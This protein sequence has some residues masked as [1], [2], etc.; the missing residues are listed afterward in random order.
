[1]YKI[2]HHLRNQ[3]TTGQKW[4]QV[5]NRLWNYLFQQSHPL[6]VLGSRKWWNPWSEKLWWQFLGFG[7]RQSCVQTGWIHTTICCLLSWCCHPWS[8]SCQHWCTIVTKV[9]TLGC[10]LFEYRYTFWLFFDIIDLLLGC[11]DKVGNKGR[12]DNIWQSPLF[13]DR[14]EP[15]GTEVLDVTGIKC[16]RLRPILVAT[17]CQENP[18]EYIFFNR[19]E[20]S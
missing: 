6:W 4:T 8:P 7:F 14:F 20:I 16:P 9:V 11:I 5:N 17:L 18:R 10:D 13:T 19:F 15:C 2:I 12:S 1:M 3:H